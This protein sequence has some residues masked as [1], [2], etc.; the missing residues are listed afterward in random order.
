MTRPQ[1]RAGSVRWAGAL[2]LAAAALAGCGVL[3]GVATSP[4]ATPTTATASESSSPEVS[5]TPVATPDPVG[6][7]ALTD[8]GA[9]H[10]KRFGEPTGEV[11]RVGT[12]LRRRY[13][14]ADLY[15]GPQTGAGSLE[16][17]ARVAF[18][19]AGG[20]DAL[21]FPIG[22]ADCGASGCVQLASGGRIYLPKGGSARVVT[23]SDT[24]RLEEVENFRDLAGEGDGLAVASGGHLMRGVVYRS[25]RLSQGSTWDRLVLDSLGVTRVFDLRTDLVAARYPDLPIAGA[26][27]KLIN[28][29]A[30]YS[31]TPVSWSTEAEAR[32][33]MR[34]MNRRFVTDPAQRRAIGTLL[35]EL[36][37]G[38]GAAIIHCTAGKDRTGWTSAVLQSLVGVSREDVMA[39]YLKS[40]EYRA[41]L[42]AAT[43]AA[44][45][46]SR[47]RSYADAHLST[48]RVRA[49]YLNAAFEEVQARYGSIENYVTKGLGVSRAEVRQLTQ[50]LVGP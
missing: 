1:G 27:S 9:A 36:A 46:R 40:N 50:R 25:G 33:A 31:G 7:A 2:L 42:I 24:V 44:E 30:V 34:A 29:F 16:G 48:L 35:K 19:A 6:V 38:R 37:G 12:G 47:G 21:G 26:T 17:S 14:K 45:V 15:Y 3:P 5:T 32:E 18:A 4:L 28:V 20:V 11:T 23:S 13:A 39:E 10:P 41:G 49:E 8:F 43:H 22:L